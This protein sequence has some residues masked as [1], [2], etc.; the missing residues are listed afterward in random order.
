[1]PA[2]VLRRV[3]RRNT[4][5]SGT[6]HKEEG[7]EGAEVKEQGKQVP[8]ADGIALHYALNKTDIPFLD[9]PVIGSI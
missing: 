3:N 8:D 4:D 1:M 2:H 9:R 7:R 6:T 5:N